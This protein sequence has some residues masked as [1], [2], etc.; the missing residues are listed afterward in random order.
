MTKLTFIRR[1]SYT[2]IEV[3]HGTAPSVNTDYHYV[4][5]FNT[6]TAP[7]TLISGTGEPFQSLLRGIDGITIP[8]AVPKLYIENGNI[9]DWRGNLV[10]KGPEQ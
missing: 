9:F 10:M 7:P 5:V 6:D 8:N 4:S 1:G 2:L 3:Y